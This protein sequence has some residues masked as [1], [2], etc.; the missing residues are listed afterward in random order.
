MSTV[1]EIFETMEYGPAPEAPDLALGWLKKIRI[2]FIH[3][4]EAVLKTR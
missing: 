1:R 3:S 2:G 4:L